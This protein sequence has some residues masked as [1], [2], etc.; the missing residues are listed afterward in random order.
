MKSDSSTLAMILDAYKSGGLTLGEAEA[1][2]RSA[3]SPVSSSPA[4]GGD[5]ARGVP[6]DGKLRFAVLRGSR[7]L[8]REDF[9]SGETY[10]VA[11]DGDVRDVD[12]SG[13]LACG[14]VNGS[15]S[16]GSSIT[17]GDIGGSVSC[18]GGIQCKSIGGNGAAGGGVRGG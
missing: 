7:I 4:D 3:L 8:R 2:L 18:G 5:T 13:S 12:C 15:A 14:Q 10:H 1:M 17:C 16:A 9:R 11:Y 6:D